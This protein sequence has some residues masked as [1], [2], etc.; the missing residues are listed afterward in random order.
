MVPKWRDG[1][2]LVFFYAEVKKEMPFTLMANR[3]AAF[4]D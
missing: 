2:G 3:N 1:I 4:P